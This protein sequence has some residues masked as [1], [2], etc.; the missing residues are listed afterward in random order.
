MSHYLG[1]YFL[2]AKIVFISE[3]RLLIDLWIKTIE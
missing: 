1:T 3:F 2:L